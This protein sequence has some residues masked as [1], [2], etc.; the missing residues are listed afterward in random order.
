[1]QILPNQTLDRMLKTINITRTE[2]SSQKK[3]ATHYSCGKKQPR[4]ASHRAV[5]DN[6]PLEKPNLLYVEK[7]VR[8]SDPN[9][10][11]P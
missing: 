7:R 10:R 9:R 2:F 8:S 6:N 3:I 11:N 5:L 4:Q 1:M